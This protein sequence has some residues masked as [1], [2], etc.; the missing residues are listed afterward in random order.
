MQRF[1]EAKPV[2][3]KGGKEYYK[4]QDRINLIHQTFPLAPEDVLGITM[5]NG[6]PEFLNDPMDPNNVVLCHG[7]VIIHTRE[8]DLTYTANAISRR[9]TEDEAALDKRLYAK[10][11]SHVEFGDTKAIGRAL[12]RAGFAGDLDEESFEEINAYVSEVGDYY[13]GKGNSEGTD[14]DWGLRF[15]DRGYASPTGALWDAFNE[16]AGKEQLYSAGHKV[17]LK[18]KAP[19][20]DTGISGKWVVYNPKRKG[21]KASPSDAALTETKAN[22]STLKETKAT[23]ADSKNSQ[24]SD[25]DKLRRDFGQQLTSAK[26]DLIAIYKGLDRALTA[27]ALKYGHKGWKPEQGK[28][29]AVLNDTQ[30]A[31]FI[32]GLTIHRGNA[33]QLG[34]FIA[35]T[36]TNGQPPAAHRNTDPAEGASSGFLDDTDAALAAFEAGTG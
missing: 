1:G 6:K 35:D 7:I 14:T 5:K 23:D 25:P 27:I 29:S 22:D 15:N 20:K 36:W 2:P 16:E 17:M 4:V 34:K 32:S 10:V 31:D 13:N 18:E 26:D 33:E 19:D 3:V 11:E 12:A 9:A 8:R 21:L 30:M 28:L 24:Q